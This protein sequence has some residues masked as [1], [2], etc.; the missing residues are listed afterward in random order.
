MK[1]EGTSVG[2]EGGEAMAVVTM[3]G[4][5]GEVMATEAA[6]AATTSP[7]LR[8]RGDHI[9]CCYE[10]QYE[11]LLGEKVLK[12]TEQ[13]SPYANGHQIEVFDSPKTHFRM[14]ANFQ[15]WRDG[16]KRNTAADAVYFAMFDPDDKRKACEVTSFPRGTRRINELM[17]DVLAILK[18]EQLASEAAAAAQQQQEA[19]SSGSGSGGGALGKSQEEMERE[20][21]ERLEISSLLRLNVFEVR[22]VTTQTEEAVVLLVYRQ[23]LPDGWHA[24]AVKAS[25]KLKGAKLVGRSRKVKVVADAFAEDAAAAAAAAAAAGGGGAAVA[26]AGG[27]SGGGGSGGGGE[28][29]SSSS[30]VVG[31]GNEV[32]EEVYMVNGKPFKIYQTE[33][34]F[35]QPNAVVCEKMLTWAS[36]VT[37]NSHDQDLLELYCGGGTFTAALAGNFRKVLATEVSKTSVELANQAFAANGI[38][39]IKIAKLS[40]EDFTAA[41]LGN[42]DFYRLTS[43]G[44]RIRDYDLH[45]V[46]VDPPRAG[47]DQATCSLLSRFDKIVYIS[48]NPD[49]LT[50][51]VGMLHNT[52]SVEKM[53]AFDQFPYTH[54]LEAGVLLV[55]RP[56]PLVCDD[57]AAESSSSSAA[58]AAAGQEEDNVGVLGKRKSDEISVKEEVATVEEGAKK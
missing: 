21:K 19:S 43:I 45:T 12:L 46:L 16:D 39:N 7:A 56:Q 47:L 55:K 35:S 22:I 41:F 18:G 33:G 1:N 23:P 50:R 5:V 27:G 20:E 34:A 2:D 13:L 10:D 28:E 57:V 3:E 48:C 9:V 44:I 32:V 17:Q 42:R 31:E 14:R 11:T 26:A 49:T 25:R 52:H 53:A 36:N 24:A 4:E 54:H 30:S 6:A 38:D 51:D 37:L 40:S 8:N 58:A 29:A 15:V